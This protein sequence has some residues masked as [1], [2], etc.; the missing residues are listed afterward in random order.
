LAVDA[1]VDDGIRIG[2]AVVDG[3]GELFWKAEDGP[4]VAELPHGAEAV[5]FSYDGKRFAVQVWNDHSPWVERFGGI[6]AYPYDPAWRITAEVRPVHA[7]R[8]VAISHYRHPEPV[9]VAVI[10]ELAFEVGGDPVRM[11]ATRGQDGMSVQFRDATNGGETYGAGRAV[12][13]DPGSD[14]EHAIM[15]FN[16]SPLLPCAFSEAWNCP[17]PARENTLLFAVRAGER[18]AVDHSGAPML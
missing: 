18:H 4:T 14:P 10:A 9:P 11:L 8:T 16:F 17:L 12:R 6:S 15:D 2:G 3:R 5:I 1:T 7:G 13:V